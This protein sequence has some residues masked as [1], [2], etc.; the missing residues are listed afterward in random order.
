MIRLP[1][2]TYAQDYGQD[3]ALVRTKANWAFLAI[4]IV[5]VFTI[6]Q[7]ASNSF[8]ALSTVIGITIISAHGLNILTGNCGLVSLG[9]SGFMM[10]GGYA[11]AILCAKGGLPFWLALPI[12][13]LMAGVVGIIFGLPSLRIKGFYLIMATV[14]AYFIIHWLVLQFRSLTGGTEGLRVPS[15]DLFGLSLKDRAHY[16][17]F[18]MVLVVIATI[19]AKNILRTR[20]GRAFVAIRD[21]DLAAEVMGVNLFSYKLQ[22]FFIG[23]VFAG[24]AGGLSVQYYLY[25]NVEQF[26]FFDS[27]WLLGMLI[28]GGMGSV[29]GAIYGAIAIKLLQQ[30]ATKIGPPLADLVNP[31]AAV[32]LG[33]IL[34]S[35]AI[36]L[37]LIFAPRGI[38]HIWERLRN[39][40]QAWPF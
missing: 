9:H 8:L 12:S 11:L 31:Q 10:V 23:N 14:A 37:F 7:W 28:V 39:Y 20:A 26:P 17:Y 25:A 3:A 38:S 1:S 16:F 27:V 24:I 18:V 36:I 40:Y 13:G 30:L 29:S 32:G 15:P 5:F 34:P 4:V 21:N 22:A 35:L 19:V 6:P 33:L 2:G